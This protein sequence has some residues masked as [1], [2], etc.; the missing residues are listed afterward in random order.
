MHVVYRHRDQSVAVDLQRREGSRFAATVDG[1]SY[2]VEAN[3]VGP[4]TL[5]LSFAG[6]TVAV[7]VARSGG[8]LHVV[9]DGDAHVF[10]PETGAA[11][12]SEAGAR[13]SPEVTA[14]MPGKVLRLFVRE[15]Q[16]VEAGDDLFILEAMKMETRITA[17]GGGTVRRVLVTEGQMVDGGQVM[18]EIDYGAQQ[19]QA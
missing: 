6:R 19:T 5:L 11:R 12:S 16:E 17:D 15:G 9:L 1:R 2:E 18:V 13:V 3:L 7:H 4:S 14:P 10:T 8:Q